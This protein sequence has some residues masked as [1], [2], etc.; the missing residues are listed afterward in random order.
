MHNHSNSLIS[1][2]YY[3]DSVPEHPPLIF[4]K[5]A[6]NADPF[7]SLRK[8]YNQANANFS[9]R[10]A[11]PCTKGSLIMFNSY[12]FHGFGQNKSTKPRVS[13]AFNVLANLSDRDT[14][15]LDFVKKERWVDN[16]NTDY[17]VKS[18]G[19]EGQNSINVKLGGNTEDGTIR[20]R[21]SR[22]LNE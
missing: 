5:V 22:Y 17:V 19:T 1:G 14:Y 11:M 13:L 21:M 6:Y 16:H 9:N 18:D 12:L 2:V 20:R 4:E 7:I 10:L 15:K 8:H 3:I